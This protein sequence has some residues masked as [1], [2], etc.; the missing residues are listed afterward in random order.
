[1]LCRI[2]PIHYM[3]DNWQVSPHRTIWIGPLCLVP[4]MVGMALWCLCR[5]EA[6]WGGCGP[7]SRIAVLPLSHSLIG[8]LCSKSILSSTCFLVLEM[9]I[10]LKSFCLF[11]WFGISFRY[12]VTTDS[13]LCADHHPYKTNYWKLS[14][15]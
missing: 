9:I 15:N 4:F 8:L 1:M 3:D 2:F 11:G 12:F 13:G 7:L 6:V 10:F 5:G 14:A